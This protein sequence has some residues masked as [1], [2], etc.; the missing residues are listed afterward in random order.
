MELTLKQE[1][2]VKIVKQ[3]FLD[4][5]KQS[6]IG[7]YAGTGKSTAVKA[8]IQSLPYINPETEYHLY[9]FYWQS[10]SSF[11]VKRKP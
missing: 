9:F 11:A 3:R 8:I 2:A 5:K 4:G 7:G 6:V 1:E 10:S